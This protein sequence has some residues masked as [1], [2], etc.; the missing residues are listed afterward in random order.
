MWH[1]DSQP[2]DTTQN[3]NQQNDTT[4]NDS[5]PNDTTQ[6]APITKMTLKIMTFGEVA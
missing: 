2:N 3:A 4:Q 5:Q 6:N 1:N